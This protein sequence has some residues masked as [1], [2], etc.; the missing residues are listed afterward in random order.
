ML[1]LQSIH[2]SAGHQRIINGITF[3][4]SSWQ[5]IGLV[6]PNWSGKTSL[7]NLINGMHTPQQGKILFNGQDISGLS[8]EHRARLGVWR[9]FQHF[10]IFKTLSL[11]ENLALAFISRMAR[12]R[13]F[14]PL[15]FLPAAYQERIYNILKEL[16]LEKKSKEPAWSLSG[17]QMRLLELARLYLQ[18][19][20]LYLLDEPTAWVSPKLKHVVI[21]LIQKIRAQGKTIII[22]E[23]DFSFISEFVD[24]V[25]VMNEWQIIATWTPQSIRE[26]QKVSEVYFG[27]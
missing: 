9:V 17:G 3:S 1:E 25:Y 20:Q 22:V 4:V 12:R 8:I 19:T 27:K 24:E 10:G 26:N 14:L 13:Q 6:W 11:E 18:D 16:D 2:R 15:H 5:A 23:H 21:A 7:L